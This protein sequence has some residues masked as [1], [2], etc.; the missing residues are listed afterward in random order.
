MLAMVLFTAWLAV[1][2]G[3]LWKAEPQTSRG[4]S[5][6]LTGLVLADRLQIAAVAPSGLARS[7]WPP[8]L[9]GRFDFSVASQPPDLYNY[10]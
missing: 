7:P 5:R 1:A 6:L 10:H 2:L 4:V 9:G 3:L 8:S